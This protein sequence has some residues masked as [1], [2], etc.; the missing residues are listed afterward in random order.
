[1]EIN[2]SFSIFERKTLEQKFT[3]HAKLL[4]NSNPLQSG[5]QNGHNIFSR[6]CGAG[7]KQARAK[8]RVHISGP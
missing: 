2:E 5:I 1:M 4:L 6:K 7:G 8:I 3:Q